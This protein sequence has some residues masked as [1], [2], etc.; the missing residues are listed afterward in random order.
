MP[1]FS[2]IEPPKIIQTDEQITAIIHLT[3]PR[4]EIRLVM[5]PAI[6]EIIAALTDQ[7]VKPAGPLFSYHWKRP[8]ETFDFEVGFPINEPI[9]PVGRVSMSKL[10][11]TKAVRT[12]Y[13]GDYEG[14]AAAW[15][16]FCE[17]IDIA[18]LN[19]QENLWEAYLVGPESSLD[20]NQWCTEL[21]RPLA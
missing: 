20:P 11:A 1:T 3:V 2:M 7:G 5:G 14:L 12:I 13:H 4:D 15:G 17:L 16:Q 21:N 6:E 18:Q 19:V 10:P 9:K 8:I